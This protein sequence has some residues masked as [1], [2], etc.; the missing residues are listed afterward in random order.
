MNARSADMSE[1]MFEVAE[2]TILAPSGLDE[3]RLSKVLDAVMNRG[4]ESFANIRCSA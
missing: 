1:P 4:V 3:G 2:R